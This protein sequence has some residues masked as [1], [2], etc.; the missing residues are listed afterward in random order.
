MCQTH[1]GSPPSSL[2]PHLP[3]TL[4]N[5]SLACPGRVPG[6]Q[7]GPE[8]KLPCTSHYCWPSSGP[9]LKFEVN[10]KEGLAT[11]AIPCAWPQRQAQTLCGGKGNGVMLLINC[12]RRGSP[13]QT[14]KIPMK[15]I[16][17]SSLCTS[18]PHDS[19]WP[20]LGLE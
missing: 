1:I 19:G 9:K 15:N 11:P 16:I 17:K 20:P 3:G 4:E 14:P 13:L 18:Q 2:I 8:W 6:C 5:K 7:L 10:L 12:G